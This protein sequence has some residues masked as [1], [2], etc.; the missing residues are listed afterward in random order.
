MKPDRKIERDEEIHLETRVVPWTRH[1][2][3]SLVVSNRGRTRGG[4]RSSTAT[5]IRIGLHPESNKAIEIVHGDT[6]DF[7]I[8]SASISH[9]HEKLDSVG[10][11]PNRNGSG[12]SLNE[13]LIAFFQLRTRADGEVTFAFFLLHECFHAGGD[14]AG[15]GGTR[16]IR[17]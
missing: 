16:T 12:R 15:G 6:Y 2:D 13:L 7:P 1:V 8:F 5:T 9:G 14:G 3:I 10:S 17:Y 11:G 4:S